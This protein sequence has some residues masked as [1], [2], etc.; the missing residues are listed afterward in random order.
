MKKSKLSL[1]LKHR[2]SGSQTITFGFP[3]YFYRFASMSPN[4]RETE[5]RPGNTRRGP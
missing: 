2:I 5:S 3:P 4:V 1:S